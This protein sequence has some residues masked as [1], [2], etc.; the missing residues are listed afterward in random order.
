MA[1][2]PIAFNIWELFL[3][4]IELD[5]MIAFRII[6]RPGLSGITNK[7]PVTQFFV[8]KNDAQFGI[9]TFLV[10]L[11]TAKYFSYILCNVLYRLTTPRISAIRK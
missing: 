9:I 2:T 5:E 3:P 8:S 6:F 10:C 4:K 11:N 7:S 1:E